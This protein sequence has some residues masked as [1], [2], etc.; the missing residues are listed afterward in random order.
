CILKKRNNAAGRIGSA[1]SVIEQRLLAHSGVVV[2]SVVKKRLKTDCRIE[3]AADV[4]C[5]R[6]GTDRCV[7][8][9]FEAE[10]EKSRI[11][12]SGVVSATAEFQKGRIAFSRIV[13]GISAIGSGSNPESF[14]NCATGEHRADEDK[15]EAVR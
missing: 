4:V 13:I 1:A 9:P 14:P 8:D 5:E 2:G 12:G 10:V 7:I 3:A 15:R 11:T 6:A